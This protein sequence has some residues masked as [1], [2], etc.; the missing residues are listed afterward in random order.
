MLGLGLATEFRSEKIPRNRIGTASVFPRNKVLIPRHSEI[1]GEHIPKLGTE[2][3]GMK[4][5]VLQKILLQQTEL[6]ACFRRRHAWEQNSE[7][8]SLPRNG[9]KQNSKCLLIFLFQGTE[10][11]VV[12]SSAEWFRTEFRV[13]AP[14]FVPWYRIPSNFLLCGTVRNGIPRIFCSAEQA[15]FCRNKPIVLVFPSSAE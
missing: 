5:F 6:I 10:F 12:F 2:G 13:F 14:N 1:Y 7:L 11:R 9:S 15:E 3:N 8:L 4:K